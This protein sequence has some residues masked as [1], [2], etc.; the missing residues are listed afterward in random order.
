MS[1]N[2]LLNCLKLL[3]HKH[4]KR[5]DYITEFIIDIEK[6]IEKYESEEKK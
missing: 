2:D 5:V 6:L 3:V 4:S 1:D